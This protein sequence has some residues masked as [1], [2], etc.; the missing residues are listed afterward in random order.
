MFDRL[1]PSGRS[2]FAT[3]ELRVAAPARLAVR[4]DLYY[5]QIGSDYVFFC[6]RSARYFS[7]RGSASDRFGRFISGGANAEDVTWLGERAIL[8]EGDEWHAPERVL[9]TRLRSSLLDRPVPPASF[10][11]TLEAILAQMRSRRELAG[12]TLADIFVDLD[13][14]RVPNN[15]VEPDICAGL[16][17]AF[18]RARRYVPAIDQCLVRG[19]AM[20]RML[21]RRKID[22]R[23]VI[24]V[25]MPFSAHCWVEV[26]D[27]ALTDPLDTLLRFEPILAV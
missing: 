3:S 20:K 7:L 19:L 17:A 26:G 10:G 23:L 11:A 4:R 18:E 15:A 24:G 2:G 27:V 12:R 25:A 16:A 6:L 14:A 5:R 9:Q 21:L 8:S 13:R 1:R 22:S